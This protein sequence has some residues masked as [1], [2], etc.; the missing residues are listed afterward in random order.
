MLDSA[1][2]PIV[3][4]YVLAG[5]G[6]T[7]G[8]LGTRWQTDVTVTSL[9][10]GGQVVTFTYDPQGQGQSATFTATFGEG[11]T[12]AFPNIVHDSFGMTGIGALRITGELR[13]DFLITARTYNTT[14]SGT[15][16]VGITAEAASSATSAT[17]DSNGK[18]TLQVDRAVNNLTQNDQF[19]TNLGLV[20]LGD[21]TASVTVT[22]YGPDGT[23][24][25]TRTDTLGPHGNV[26]YGLAAL[27]TLPVENAYA[28]VRCD[29]PVIVHAYRINNT[30]GQNDNIAGFPLTTTF[31]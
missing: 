19:R 26:Q 5:V 11:E 17:F 27:T 21:T 1:R 2:D 9:A 18:K 15:Y 12:R 7:N 28:I 13:H 25:G 20:N 31:P 10:Q 3:P 24:L 16:G 23:P 4:S 14:I 29:Q 6:A 8:Q 30:T 22:A